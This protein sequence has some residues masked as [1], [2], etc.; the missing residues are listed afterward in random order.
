MLYN[1][2]HHIFQTG[3]DPLHSGQWRTVTEG[4]VGKYCQSKSPSLILGNQH[5]DKYV[6]SKDLELSPGDVLQFKVMEIG[7]EMKYIQQNTNMQFFNGKY[8]MVSSCGITTG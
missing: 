5:N 6:I 2:L 8:S 1:S 7:I 4:A 3:V